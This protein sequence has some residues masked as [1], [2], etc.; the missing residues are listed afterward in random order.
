MVDKRFF[1]SLQG[2]SLADICALIDGELVFGNENQVV[3]SVAPSD[4]VQEGELCFINN[5]SHITSLATNSA[6]VILTNKA[7]AKQIEGAAAVIIVDNPRAAFAIVSSALIEEVN[8]ATDMRHLAS[9]DATAVIDPTATISAFCH[10]GAHVV[11]GGGVTIG[12]GVYV[13]AGV[14][15]GASCHI[16]SHVHIETCLLGEAVKIGPNTVIGKPGFGFEMTSDGAVPMPH[17][18]RVTIGN[19]CMIGANCTIDRGVMTDTVIGNMVMVDNQVHIAHNVKVGDRTMILAQ[20]GIA[21]SVVVGSDCI[22]AAQVGVKDHIEITSK[23]VILSR[24]A[25]TK[26]ILKPG[27]YAGFPAQAAKDEWREQASLKRLA[28]HKYGKGKSD[29]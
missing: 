1:R 15:I 26:S 12:P 27:T 23:T 2:R 3:K 4:I 19:D 9:I 29:D 13:G 6:A 21:G 16:G 25:V 20:T 22:I 11:I 24:A 18:G 17:L 10:I 28:K 14:V 5:R 7:T 8:A